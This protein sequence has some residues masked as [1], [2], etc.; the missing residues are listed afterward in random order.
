MEKMVFKSKDPSENF[1]LEKQMG[2]YDKEPLS[3]N[4]QSDKNI[5]SLVKKPL[6]ELLFISYKPLAY[7]LN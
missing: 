1:G 5:F 7:L 6:I 3:C 4:G 2:V